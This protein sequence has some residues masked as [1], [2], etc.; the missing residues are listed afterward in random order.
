MKQILL[1]ILLF[2]LYAGLPSIVWAKCDPV[3]NGPFTLTNQEPVDCVPYAD[4][5]W[6]K[7]LPVDKMNFVTPYSA[8]VV[9]RVFRIFSNPFVGL[10]ATPGKDDF[11]QIPVVYGTANDPYWK[12][13]VSK[14]ASCGVLG[15]ASY[16]GNTVWRIPNGTKWT[17]RGGTGNDSFFGVYDTTKDEYLVMY[18]SSG[19]SYNLLQGCSA[20]KPENACTIPGGYSAT[21]MHR[22]AS[23]KNVYQL[24]NPAGD[25]MYNAARA[26]VIR[27]QELMAGVINHPIYL[28]FPCENTGSVFPSQHQALACAIWPQGS[29]IYGTPDQMP[30]HGNLLFL[31]YTDAQIDAMSVPAWQKAL[32]KAF[33]NYGAY[34]GDTSYYP[35]IT[36]QRFE[37]LQPWYDYYGFADD[38]PLSTVRTK[39]P[40]VDWLLKQGIPCN[41]R[42]EPGASKCSFN[43]SIAANVP[44]LIGPKCSTPCGFSGHVHIADPC[45]AR[46]LAGVSGG[47]GTQGS[48][49]VPPPSAPPIS[50]APPPPSSPPPASAPA[51]PS[52]PK[53]LRV[54]T[55][56]P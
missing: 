4:S 42:S 1:R 24:V 21:K 25:T 48:V 8:K 10:V 11:S 46:G 54:V 55:I 49:S 35:A 30:Y 40:V 56:T 14:C 13:D 9:Q 37:S 12:V 23:G 15:S 27:H 20:T 6:A 28:N 33:A 45:V 2:T 22:T 34:V 39:V 50:S 43:L 36:V 5:V 52:A 17:E 29:W 31:D 44:A 41:T 32:L 7:R 53:N 47:C 18:K 51:Q 16:A 3:L 38:T 26:M 19:P